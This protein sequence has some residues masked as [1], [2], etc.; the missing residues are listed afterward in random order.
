MSVIKLTVLQHGNKLFSV[1]FF[2]SALLV[3]RLLNVVIKQRVSYMDLSICIN[4]NMVNLDLYMNYTMAYLLI[5]TT[6]RWDE[7]SHFKMPITFLKIT[8]LKMYYSLLK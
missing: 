5:K 3:K 4:S 7:F 2:C 1:I 8:I 6:L